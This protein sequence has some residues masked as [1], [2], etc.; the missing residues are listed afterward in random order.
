MLNHVPLFGANRF[1][2]VQDLTIIMLSKSVSPDTIHPMETVVQSLRAIFDRWRRS[3][4]ILRNIGLGD[5]NRCANLGLP[6][7]WIRL[8]GRVL[9]ESLL[10]RHWWC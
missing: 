10:T 7:F 3:L 4:P 9:F 8:V 1:R 2:K 6:R 5:K